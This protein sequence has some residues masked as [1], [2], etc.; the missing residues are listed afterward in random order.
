VSRVLVISFTDL[1]ADPRVD[2][3]I[4]MLRQRHDVLAAGLGPPRRDGIDF[5]ALEDPPRTRVGR[6][7]GLARLLARRY[8][9]VYW[10]HP[11]NRRALEL[12]AGLECDAVVANDLPALPLALALPGAPPVVFDAHEYAP[13]EQEELRWW[14]L[15]MGPYVRWLCSEHIPRVAAMM[16]VAPSI[17]EAYEADTGVPCAVVTNAPPRADLRPTAA[18]EPVRILHHGIA[19]PARRLEQMIRVIE[20]LDER[21]TLDLVLADG[22][23]A[24][25]RQLM[26]RAADQPRVSFPPPRPMDA[27]VRAANDYDI[28]LYLLAPA[29]FNQ[30][31]ALPNK[32]FEFI[33][34]RLAVAVGPSP[35]MAA[36]VREHGVG[37]VAEDF[38]AEAM[39]RAL[40]GLDRPRI[41]E[42]K[43]RSHAAA[44]LLCAESNTPRVLELVEQALAR[45]TGHGRPQA[46][47]H[48]DA[49][50]R[51]ASS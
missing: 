10:C 48:M 40:R 27:L 6:L 21:F 34:A 9:D 46:P 38:T 32:I 16:T 22:D 31:H 11:V 50:G 29:N 23:P 12:L 41:D 1:A 14:R 5:V 24:Y 28:G 18:H 51:S 47:A 49:R 42:L 39:A 3:Q 45:A 43:A 2:R 19:Q 7:P 26:Q 13:R 20:L 33:Q 36:V 44:Q 8:R 4:A 17:A 37:V 35:E 30:R 25:R 15:L